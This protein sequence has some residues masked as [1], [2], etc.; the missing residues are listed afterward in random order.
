MNEKKNPI[1]DCAIVFVIINWK[2]FKNGS[3]VWIPNA[4]EMVAPTVD[5]WIE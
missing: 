4:S 1:K 5:Q 2:K 3:M